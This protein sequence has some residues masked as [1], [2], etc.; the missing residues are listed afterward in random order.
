MDE[1]LL[2][3]ARE[4]GLSREAYVQLVRT[5][6]QILFPFLAD[7]IALLRKELS[8][9]RTLLE[10]LLQRKLEDTEFSKYDNT[11]ENLKNEV[12]NMMEELYE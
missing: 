11:I 1:M 8:L 2:D 5:G 6:V 10:E 12:K 9:H 4:N 7:E 3:L